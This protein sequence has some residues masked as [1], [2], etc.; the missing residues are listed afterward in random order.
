[1][2]QT[3]AATSRDGAQAQAE[4]VQLDKALG[5]ELVV[6]PLVLLEGDDILRVEAI[7]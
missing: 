1:M 2:L 5:V 7:G 3:A 6:C 4:S